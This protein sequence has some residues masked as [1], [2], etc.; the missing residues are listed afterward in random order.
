MTGR[1]QRSLSR[2]AG[3][4][5]V[6]PHRAPA[7]SRL[8]VPLAALALA[9]PLA[10]C[11]DLI[12]EVDIRSNGT[13][14]GNVRIEIAEEAATLLGIS[15]A[16]ELRE[17]VLQGELGGTNTGGLTEEGCEVDEAGSALAV[18][19]GFR[20]AEFTDPEGLWVIERVEETVVFRYR[21]GEDTAAQADPEALDLGVSLGDVRITA[22]FPGEILSV[23]GPNTVEVDE[24]TVRISGP[25]DEAFEVTVTAEAGGG[26]PVGALLL[27]LGIIVVAGG[28]L[29]MLMWLR[30]RRSGGP[31][32]LPP[33]GSTLAQPGAAP[34]PP[35]GPPP[36]S[37][38]VPGRPPGPPAPPSP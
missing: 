25:I 26:A 6:R 19:C 18:V 12:A 21:N 33:V 1:L 16:E 14:S 37:P 2:R 10:G 29:A 27:G 36:A 11:V 35:P 15:N 28:V 23:N 24:R 20:N 38:P 34:T 9:G 8:A 7:W 13:G 4:P 3:I 17:E 5:N 32:A 22:T 30:S 31:G